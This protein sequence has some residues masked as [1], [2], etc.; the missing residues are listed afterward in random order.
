[1]P[2]GTR[3]FDIPG[4]L[5]RRLNQHSMAHFHHLI[6][7]AGYDITSIQFAALKMLA[8]DPGI[9]QATLA[10]LIEYDRATIGDVVKRL[11]QK[12]LI[13]R[14]VNPNDKRAY[15]LTLSPQGETL[16]NK[17]MP[18]V[19]LAESDT[20]SGLTPSEKDMLVSLIQKVLHLDADASGE[21][22]DK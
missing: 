8:D 9:D 2:K 12:G 19:A 7:E 20:L 22:D 1:M 16:L 14:Q 11:H 10:G 6:R 21:P 5:F 18:I 15:S 3:L 17:T 13:E 4:H